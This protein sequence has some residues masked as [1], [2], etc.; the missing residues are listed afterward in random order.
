MVSF[1]LVSFHSFMCSDTMPSLA[2]PLRSCC[3]LCTDPRLTDYELLLQ[4]IQDLKNDKD[5]EV[6]P[7]T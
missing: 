4:N 7:S 1:G 6:C 2:V 3:S 5:V